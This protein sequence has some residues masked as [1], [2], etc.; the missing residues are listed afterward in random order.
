MDKKSIIS[1]FISIVASFVV[2]G[3]VG[4]FTEVEVNSMAF[5]ALLIGSFGH[6]HLVSLVSKKIKL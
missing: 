4:T 5:L 2:V 6:R 3:M 1:N